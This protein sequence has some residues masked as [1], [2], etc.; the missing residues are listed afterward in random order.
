M[1]NGIINSKVIYHDMYK[2]YVELYV[3]VDAKRAPKWGLHIF[4]CCVGCSARCL[5][6]W[7]LSHVIW[8]LHC[9]VKLHKS[10]S[11]RDSVFV[12]IKHF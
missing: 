5:G 10:R 3:T 1:Y 11:L 12:E 8:R 2:R 4:S 7:R 6:Y 9:E